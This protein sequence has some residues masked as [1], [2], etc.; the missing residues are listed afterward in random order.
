MIQSL[1]DLLLNL[2]CPWQ[3]DSYNK[4]RVKIS[5]RSHGINNS[6]HSWSCLTDLCLYCY[7]SQYNYGL[8]Y[9]TLSKQYHI[10]PLY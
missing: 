5:L 3:M 6:T 9:L 10:C 7:L 4:R 1:Q 8:D 2:I